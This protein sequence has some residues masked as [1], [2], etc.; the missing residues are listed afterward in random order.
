M[1]PEERRAECQVQE[2]E[3]K[4]KIQEAV[5]LAREYCFEDYAQCLEKISDCGCHGM[6]ADQLLI[7]LSG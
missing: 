6:T 3:I 1:T 5:D 2:Q 7:K 4:A